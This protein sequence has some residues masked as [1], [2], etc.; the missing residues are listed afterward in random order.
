MIQKTFLGQKFFHPPKWM[1]YD[2]MSHTWV[3]TTNWFIIFP[4]RIE[5]NKYPLVM[6]NSL[7]LKMAIEIVDLPI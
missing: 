6:T 1:K 2:D 4:D 3:M 5:N 7:L